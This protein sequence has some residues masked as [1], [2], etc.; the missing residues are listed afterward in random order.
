MEKV[1]ILIRIALDLSSALNAQSRYQ[2]LLESLRRAIPYDAAALLQIEGDQ[3]WVKAA[4]GLSEDAR[5]RRFLR[6]EHPRLDIICRSKTA[7]RFAA[8]SPIPDP[9]D[10]L[11][12]D[13]AKAKRRI[14]SCLGCPLY[15]G[16]VLIG[17]LT[18]DAVDPKAFDGLELH[19]IEAIA[20]LA[21][22]EMHAT[23]L[24]QALEAGAEKLGMIAQDLMRDAQR[25]GGS[26]M[27]GTSRVMERLRREIDL[28]ARSDFAILVT[29]ETG[30][31]KELVA[32]AIHAASRRK[33]QPILS[34]NCASLPETLAESELFGHVKGAFTGAAGERTGKFELADGGTLFLDEVGEL[35]L[36][37]QPKLLRVLQ[38]GEVQ[39]IGSER[40]QHVDVRL[41][42][43]TNRHLEREV[44][45]GRFRADL[46]HRLNVYPLNVAPLREREADIAQLA[47]HFIQLAQRRIGIGTVR[48]GQDALEQLKR[49]PWPGNV[50]ELENVI[51]RAVLKASA[52]ASQG[53]PVAIAARHLGL[54]SETAGSAAPV[55]QPPAE[56]FL[57]PD[58]TLRQAVDEFQKGYILQAVRQNGNN[59]AA[60]ARQLGL[61]R[62]NLHKLAGRLKVK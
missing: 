35:P 26:E 39:K 61:H 43:A 2:R 3:L 44:A 50:R 18:A 20:A 10:H 58:L 5:G 7:V 53:G 56:N 23:N 60:A 13:E 36:S 54:A 47:G 27:I 8:D 6:R 46:Y 40:V 12:A 52:E 21:G 57:R 11:L 45:V 42:A 49:Y 59:W 1:D 24:I 29:G 33:D 28:V 15:A 38:E 9:F 25:G 17:A 48:L 41:I 37:V 14:H 55:L 16:S 62:S 30:T 31:G 22:A 32:R 19:F 51:L 34:V 4:Q